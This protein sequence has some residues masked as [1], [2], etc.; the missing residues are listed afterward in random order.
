MQERVLVTG[1]TGFVGANLVRRLLNQNYDVFAFKRAASNTWRLNEI[2]KKIR[3]IDVDLKNFNSVKFAVDSIKPQIIFHL[4]AYGTNSKENQL[5]EIVNTNIVGTLNLLKSIRPQTFFVNTGT[6]WEY[7]PSD[8]K[9]SEDGSLKP[10]NEY[11]ATKT[12]VSYFC[13][14]FCD[15]YNYKITTLRPFNVYGL[16]EDSPRLIPYVILSALNKK[17]IPLTGGK[18]K[19]DFIFVEDL[20]DA[21]M[22]T[23]NN[24]NAIGE[25]FNIGTGEE[26]SVRNAVETIL[27]IMKNPVIA[28]FGAQPYR[29][30]E[31][32]HSC[33]NISKAR[34]ILKWKPK[35]SLDD[36]LETTIN[37]FKENIGKYN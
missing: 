16:F 19:K 7:S 26:N 25:I 2:T 23:I 32:W 31:I 30:N 34:K 27:Q 10:M 17:N 18:Q 1:A 36:G 29:K 28:E 35:N 24:E 6:W 33:A 11:A 5:D 4:A 37:W 9:I 15:S 14:I 22:S 20:A 3:I 21:Y 8:E 12:V 13:K